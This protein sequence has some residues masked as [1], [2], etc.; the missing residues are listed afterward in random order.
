MSTLMLRSDHITFMGHL[1]TKDGLQ[2]DPEKIKAITDFPVPQK[3]EELR[4]FLGMV[5]YRFLPSV[6]S[7]MHPLHNLLKKDVRWTWSEAQEEFFKWIKEMIA[8]CPLLTFYDPNK[9]LTLEND[10]SEY[11]LGSAHVQEGWCL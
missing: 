9:E 11:G 6:T 7:E 5:N 10:A 8:N 4:C 3:L 1:I 2:T